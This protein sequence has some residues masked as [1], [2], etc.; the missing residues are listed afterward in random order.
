MYPLGKMTPFMSHA[1][2]STFVNVFGK[3]TSSQIIIFELTRI[4]N[5][6]NN[7]NPL[8]KPPYLYT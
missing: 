6:T 3:F 8:L 5:N 2:T 4:I 1:N 7:L